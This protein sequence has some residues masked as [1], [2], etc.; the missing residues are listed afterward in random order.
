MQTKGVVM[1][2]NTSKRSYTIS[3]QIISNK[4]LGNITKPKFQQFYMI[5]FFLTLFFCHFILFSNKIHAFE[6][7]LHIYL[8]LKQNMLISWAKSEEYR[9]RCIFSSDME[10]VYNAILKYEESQA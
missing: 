6:I 1:Y 2:I 9:N 10:F 3:Y 4:M 7:S 5:S 8:Y